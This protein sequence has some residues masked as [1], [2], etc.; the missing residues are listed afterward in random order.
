ML[1][2]Q[3]AMEE[4]R[5]LSGLLDDGLAAMRRLANEYAQTEATYR[6]GKAHAW[7]ATRTGDDRRLSVTERTAIVDS[8]TADLRM[9]RDLAEAMRQAALESVRSRRAQ[10]SAWQSLLAAERE[11][12]AMARTGPGG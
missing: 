10:V 6:K 4:M 12:M 3:E 1:D 9:A 11:E 5:R 7:L 8:E 2:L